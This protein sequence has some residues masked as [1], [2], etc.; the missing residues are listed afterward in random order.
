MGGHWYGYGWESQ[1]LETGFLAAA[2]SPLG[3]T[4]HPPPSWLPVVG[5]RWLLFRIMLGSGLIKLR[6]SSSPCWRCWRPGQASC[7]EYFYETQ[8][9]PSPLARRLHFM[10][11]WFHS[12]STYTNHVVELLLPW[13]LLLPPLAGTPFRSLTVWG[14][15]VAQLSFQLMLCA[16]GNLSFLNVLTM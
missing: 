8:P 4:R 5:F 15:G 16:S 6:Q 11:P 14:G 2:A 1:L 13:L 9:V 10:P 3:L 12:G 7:M